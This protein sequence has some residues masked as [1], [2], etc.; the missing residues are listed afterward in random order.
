[1]YTSGEAPWESRMLKVGSLGRQDGV[2]VEKDT[3]GVES[4][5]VQ[6]LKGERSRCAGCG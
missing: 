3:P 5:P 6:A 4:A 2:G 1:M